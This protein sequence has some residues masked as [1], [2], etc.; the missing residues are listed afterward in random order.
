MIAVGKKE[1]RFK[2]EREE[3]DGKSMRYVITRQEQQNRSNKFHLW[4]Q[5]AYE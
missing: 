5:R 1:K 4:E 3:R 2:K